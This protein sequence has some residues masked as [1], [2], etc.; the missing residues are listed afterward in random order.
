MTLYTYDQTGNLTVENA[1]GSLLTNVF[2]NENRL[3]VTQ[4]S[5]NSLS[6]YTYAGDGLR[7]SANQAG[8]GVVTFIW[9]GDSYL[10]EKS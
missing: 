1:N 5:N 2:D 10:M 8:A 9:D 4:W 6:T 7:R 3:L